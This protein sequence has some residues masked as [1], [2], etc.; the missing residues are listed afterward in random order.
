MSA[1]F[2]NLLTGLARFP[3]GLAL[4]AIGSKGLAAGLIHLHT[5]DAQAF[6]SAVTCLPLSLVFLVPSLARRVLHAGRHPDTKVWPGVA[7]A[8]VLF[9]LTFAS[10]AFA[11]GPAGPV[12]GLV[13]RW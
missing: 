11:L 12:F 8:V 3:A 4:F 6:W 10:M 2:S 7:A 5:G 13:P 1:R 9:I